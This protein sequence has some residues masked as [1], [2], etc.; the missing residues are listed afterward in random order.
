MPTVNE[1]I[2]AISATTR[3]VKIAAATVALETPGSADETAR[4]L[5]EA[6]ARAKEFRD[7]LASKGES[8]GLYLL[9]K[10]HAFERLML[11][12]GL[13]RCERYLKPVVL[14]MQSKGLL[15]E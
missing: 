4:R 7:I 3:V 6:G 1:M 14:H 9:S 13:M 10:A 5:E 8:H 11:Q 12:R 2:S 15:N